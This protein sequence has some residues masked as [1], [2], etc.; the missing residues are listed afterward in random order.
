MC[1]RHLND[2][3]T[4]VDKEQVD[5]SSALEIEHPIWALDAFAAG[6]RVWA[7]VLADELRPLLHLEPNDFAQ[8]VEG[9]RLLKI[10]GGGG[11]VRLGDRQELRILGRASSHHGAHPRSQLWQG[12][13]RLGVAAQKATKGVP[14][15]GVDVLLPP[16]PNG[17]GD[18]TLFGVWV[19]R[20]VINLASFQAARRLFLHENDVHHGANHPNVGGWLH[21]IPSAT[22][23][24]LRRHVKC[25]SQ[26]R[27]VTVP[28]G[29][30]E[31]DQLKVV[32]FLDQHVV[33]LQVAMDPALLMQV[34]DRLYELVEVAQPLGHRHG[35]VRGLI[36]LN[37]LKQIAPQ[38]I[39][40]FQHQ[41]W[42]MRA[43]LRRWQHVQELDNAWVL[44]P[45]LQYL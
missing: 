10:H 35:A 28:P 13:S 22:A 23:D 39:D 7:H 9:R 8:S 3:I 36:A 32:P 41:A 17:S 30:A 4:A 21:C 43:V 14:H 16:M 24:E 44:N 38:R 34:P 25:S 19:Q 2:L 12:P 45:S 42:S 26:R 6:H 18:S 31:V 27:L 33:G 11:L 20:V 1:L 15:R 5:P 40:S 29:Y 37:D